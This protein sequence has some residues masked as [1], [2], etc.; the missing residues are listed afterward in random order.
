MPLYQSGEVGARI[1]QNVELR[2]QLRQ[3]I[4]VARLQVRSTVSAAWSQLIAVKSQI[5]SYRS[6]VEATRLRLKACARK[7]TSVSAR[8][9]T[10]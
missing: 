5:V 6:Q 1:R 2:S 8:C 9:S 4:D 3:Q 7:R 10:C